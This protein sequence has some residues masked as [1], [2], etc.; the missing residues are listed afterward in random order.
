M[1]LFMKHRQT[2]RHR[3]MTCS[4]QR[5]G[6]WEGDGLGLADAPYYI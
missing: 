1:S 2:H 5:G 6:D 3:E 4:C